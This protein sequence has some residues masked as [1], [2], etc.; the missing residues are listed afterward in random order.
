[1]NENHDTLGVLNL[2]TWNATDTNV[3]SYLKTPIQQSSF[4]NNSDLI[5]KTLRQAIIDFSDTLN[6]IDRPSCIFGNEFCSTRTRKYQVIR[7]TN[8]NSET[9]AMEITTLAPIAFEHIRSAIGITRHDFQL[10]F[11]NGELMNFT[12]TGKSGSQMYKTNDEVKRNH[13]LP[14]HKSKQ[15]LFRYM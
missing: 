11:T 5:G 6:S 7:S 2:N 3:L 1:M 15:I 13:I 4:V 14:Y 9:T 8:E 10:S 12:N